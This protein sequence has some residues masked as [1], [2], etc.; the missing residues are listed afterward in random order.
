[1]LNDKRLCLEIKFDVK[2]AYILPF[3]FISRIF[4]FIPFPPLFMSFIFFCLYLSL[5]FPCS[6]VLYPLFFHYLSPILTLISLSSFV[7]PLSPFPP[8]FLF[9]HLHLH[10]SG[11]FPFS[12]IFFPFFHFLFLLPTILPFLHS[13]LHSFV[14][15]KCMLRSY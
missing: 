7:P 15:Y 11:L 12:S 14:R 3:F 9:F 5:F 13:F 10:L 8:L 6:P 4:L 2:L 1:V